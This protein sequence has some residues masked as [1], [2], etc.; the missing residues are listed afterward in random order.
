MDNA[1]FM[2]EF[3]SQVSVLVCGD[4]ASFIFTFVFIKTEASERSEVTCFISYMFCNFRT[5][6]YT[7][8]STS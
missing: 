3:F 8:V 5:S 4:S 1:A 2:D 6:S 7:F